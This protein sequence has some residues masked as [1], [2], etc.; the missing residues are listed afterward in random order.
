VRQLSSSEKNTGL[1]LAVPPPASF[2]KYIAYV[3]LLPIAWS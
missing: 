3:E 2:V 1:Y